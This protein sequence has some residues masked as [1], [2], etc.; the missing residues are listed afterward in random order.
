MV[1]DDSTTVSRRA[2]S[3]IRI[4]LIGEPLGLLLS[5]GKQGKITRRVL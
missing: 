5:K 2:I 4:T 1:A 3:M